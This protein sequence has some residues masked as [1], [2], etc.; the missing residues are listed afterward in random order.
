MENKFDLTLKENIFLAKKLLVQS[1]YNSAKVES[2]NIT[3]PQTQTIMDGMSVE[4][5]S[6]SDFEKVINLRDA[7]KFC[8][9]NIDKPLTLDYIC[10]INYYAARNESLDWGVLRYGEIVISGTDFIPKKP[11]RE[12]V[13]LELEKI[14]TGNESE[15][16]K[17]INLFMWGCRS[18]LFWDGNKRTSTIIANKYL[19]S[20][21]RGILTIP[22]G[23]LLEFNKNLSYYYST[24][25][26]EPLKTFLYEK[27]IKGMT[28]EKL[29]VE[30]KNLE[31]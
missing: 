31:R 20:N 28:V 27:C 24:N 5:L 29:K 6:I 19:I 23:N 16:E 13:E 10:K 25:E 9:D 2:I 15:T 22:E 21:G 12:N 18:Q 11:Q 14:M 8:L 26:K 30:D 3:F 7:W 1:I 4:G 17:A